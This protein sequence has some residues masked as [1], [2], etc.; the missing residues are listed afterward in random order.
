M[1]QFDIGSGTGRIIRILLRV[2]LALTTLI[3]P[4]FMDMMSAAGW[5]YNVSEGN[6]PE[7]FSTFAVWMFF[8]AG[9]L[10]I[11]AVLCFFGM[12]PKRWQCNAAA[13]GCGCVGITACLTVLYKFC[14]YAD[15][16]F[17]G[18][19]ETMQPVS[20]LYRDRILPTLL[21]FAILCVLSAWQL[22]SYDA[23]VYR[24]QKRDAKRRADAQEAPKILGE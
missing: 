5:Q 8:G 11:A 6:Y 13:L 20:E 2:L 12:K 18:I 9:L 15:Q 19:A 10:T 14:A 24:R 3:Y 21:P 16:N 17:S 7:L 4:M 1:K 23:H 22:M